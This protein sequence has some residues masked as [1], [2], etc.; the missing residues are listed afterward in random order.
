MA[1]SQIKKSLNEANAATKTNFSLLLRSNCIKSKIIWYF[2]SFND[3]V[4][5]NLESWW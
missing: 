4:Y 2:D 1:G 5:L 3:V